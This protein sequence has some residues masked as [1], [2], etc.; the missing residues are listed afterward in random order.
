MRARSPMTSVLLSALAK[1]AQGGG[2]ALAA[3]GRADLPHAALFALI[4]RGGAALRAAGIGPQDRLVSLLDTGPEAASL[5]LTLAAQAIAAPLNPAYRAEEIA[6][7]LDDLR[8]RAFLIAAGRDHPARAVARD[9]GIAIIEVAAAPALA[10]GDF[11]FVFPDKKPAPIAPVART[12]SRKIALL[13]H[14][15]GT[16]SRPKLVPLGPDN[17]LASAQHIAAILAL[18]P[19]DRCLNLMPL[20][21]IHGLVGA[22]LSSILAGGSLYCPPGFSALRFFEDLAAARASWITAVPTMYQAVLAR[23]ARHGEIIAAHPLRFLRSSS[24]PLPAPVMQEIE[25]V[26]GAPVIESYGMTEAAHQMA[27]NPLPPG[28]RKPGSVGRAAGPEIAIMAEDGALLPPDAIGEIVIRGPNVMAGYLDNPDANA[29]AFR[30]GWFRTGDQGFLDGEGYLVLTGRLKE[31]INR[32]GEKIAP[33]E[34]DAA[35]AAHPAIAQAIAFAV[36]HEKLGEEIAAAIVLRSGMKISETEIRDF[37]AVRLA[38]FKLP[39]RFLFLDEI[40]KGPTGKLQ[41]LGL[42][43]TLGLA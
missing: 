13:L 11:D 8:P 1:A 16:T 10:A 3:P 38:P 6:F 31:L 27:S 43:K 25:R 9:K 42:A 4:E 40:P 24:A 39:R 19:R 12:E 20:F 2:I 33:L 17:L 34:I 22:V 15:S 36:P 28:K 23:A 26:F 7:F 5:F 21:H 35:L 14:T 41:R 29:A 30:A 18:T 37:L 32:G